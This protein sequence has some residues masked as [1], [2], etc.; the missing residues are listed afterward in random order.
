MW[1]YI[2]GALATPVQTLH[3]VAER[4]LWKQGLII[5]A[6]LSLLKGASLTATMGDESVLP[7]LEMTTGTTGLEAVTS[8]LESP[9]FLLAATFFGGILQWLLAGVLF[10]LFARLFKGQGT[11]GGVLS[12]IGFAKTPNFIGIPLSTLASVAGGLAFLSGIIEFGIGIW[13]AVL[14]IIAI[15]E[16]YRIGTGAATATFFI[17]F[18][19]LFIALFFI[20]VLL[21][22][23]SF[24]ALP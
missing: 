9:Y 23:I 21:A 24:L 10:H 3:S 20:G 18:I 6:V 14:E 1:E 2:P 11:V 16:N 17:P 15:R 5:V 19:L 22:F 8:I 12:A 7:L 13:I 4:N